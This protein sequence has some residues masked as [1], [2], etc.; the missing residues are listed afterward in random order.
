[1]SESLQVAIW[2]GG[3]LLLYAVFECLKMLRSIEKRASEVEANVFKLKEAVDRI[4]VE[5]MLGRENLKDLRDVPQRAGN[6][7]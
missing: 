3:A 1:M 2:I 6:G 5:V 7:S 4:D